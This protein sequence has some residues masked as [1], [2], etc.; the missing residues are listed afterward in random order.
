MTNKYYTVILSVSFN[1]I[2]YNINELFKKTPIYPN[3]RLFL[4]KC[5]WRISKEI[6]QILMNKLKFTQKLTYPNKIF[7]VFKAFIQIQAGLFR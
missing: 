5:Y 2:R 7:N 3:K 6:G 4:V 1:I